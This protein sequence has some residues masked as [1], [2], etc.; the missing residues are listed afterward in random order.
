MDDSRN[1]T[2][3]RGF[4]WF[5]GLLPPHPPPTNAITCCLPAGR[6][7]GDVKNRRVET[8]DVLQ[9]DEPSV[10][11][12]AVGRPD[13]LPSGVIG[14][15]GHE[16]NGFRPV[17]YLPHRV[18]CAVARLIEGPRIDWLRIQTTYPQIAHLSN[19][20]AAPGRRMQREV[21]PL[22]APTR[23]NGREHTAHRR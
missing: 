3:S 7:V 5:W 1:Q 8:Y 10:G 9:A 11:Q 21:R 18:H 22:T 17:Q 19:S 13:E 6:Q 2:V 14:I 4:V 23:E 12:R 16:Q 20:A 15:M